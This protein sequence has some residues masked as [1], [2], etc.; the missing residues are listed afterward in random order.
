MVIN[1]V[2]KTL[3]AIGIKNWHFFSRVFRRK[4]SAL[5]FLLKNKIELLYT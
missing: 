4:T 1:L 5:N 2:P 3:A